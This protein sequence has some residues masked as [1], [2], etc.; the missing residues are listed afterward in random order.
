MLEFD[1]SI[2]VNA[3]PDACWRVLSTLGDYALWNPAVPLVKGTLAQGETVTLQLK[4]AGR[5]SIW[6][7]VTVQTFVAPRALVWRSTTV[8]RLL[9]VEHS[10]LLSPLESGTRFRNVETFAGP[11]AAA[12]APVLRQLMP[13]RYVV[14]NQAF[15]RHCEAS[16]H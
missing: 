6:T 7:P 4:L 10:F 15:K 11:L 2:A 8:P 1:T 3:S 12:S 14:F 13:S 5:V 9:T 16:A